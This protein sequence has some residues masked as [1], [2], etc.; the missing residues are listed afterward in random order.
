MYFFSALAY[1]KFIIILEPKSFV[2]FLQVLFVLNFSRPR[3][4]VKKKKINY[5]LT[6][7]KNQEKSRPKN[8]ELKNKKNKICQR[9]NFSR[10][11]INYS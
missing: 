7:A 8:L 1:Q 3:R 10:K 9:I 5:S 4:G 6:K 2:A 11:N